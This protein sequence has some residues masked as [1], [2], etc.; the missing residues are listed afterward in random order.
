MGFWG[1]AMQALDKCG[2][3]DSAGEDGNPASESEKD[4][5]LKCD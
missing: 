3:A 5:K 4:G 2:N 1:S